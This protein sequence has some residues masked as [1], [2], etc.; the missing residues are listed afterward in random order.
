MSELLYPIIFMLILVICEACFLQ[1][2]RKKKIDW[3]DVI[4]NLNSGHIVLWMFR[5]LEVLCY[6]LILQYANLHLYDGVAAGWVWLFTVVAWD[7]CFYWLHRLHHERRWLWAVHVVHHQGEHY[8]LSL[9]VRNSWYSSLTGIPFFMVLA[10]CGVPL[11]VYLTV[12]VIHYTVQFFNHNALTPRLG[13]LE[14]VFITPSHHRVHHLNEKRYADTNYGGTFLIWD[15]LF[16]TYCKAPP[17]ESV[18]FGVKGS[19]LSGN[20]LRESNVPFLKLFGLAPSQRQSERQ[21]SG[22]T[23]ILITGALL[24]FVLV[25]GY[26]QRYG[27]QIESISPEQALL[28][29][30]LAAGTVALGGISDGQRWG[31]RVWGGVTLLLLVHPLLFTWHELL[32]RVTPVLL[33]IHG[34]MVFCGIGSRTVGAARE[35]V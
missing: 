18:E 5:C 8:N 3:R 35:S 27:Y 9:G 30:L 24:L 6:A 1:W 31:K 4:F 21:S 19:Q 15:R 2:S 11:T 32:W 33:V 13:W 26:I 14:K 22:G 10:V 12:S 25:L 28:V 16:G 34:M 29:V 23:M 17:V 7:L 20:P